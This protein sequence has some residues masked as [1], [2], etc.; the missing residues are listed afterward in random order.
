MHVR[1]RGESGYLRLARKRWTINP[2]ME[3]GKPHAWE[4]IYSASYV[5]F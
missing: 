5:T 1:C 3:N 2:Y 4:G